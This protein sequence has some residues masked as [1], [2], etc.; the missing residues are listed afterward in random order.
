MARR[1]RPAHR[2]RRVR[3]EPEELQ[4]GHLYW[5]YGG[6]QRVLVMG[7]TSGGLPYGLVEDSES[8]PASRI[9]SESDSDPF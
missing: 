4:D 5:D 2:P 7:Y 9:D 6:T 1:H 8:A 3:Q